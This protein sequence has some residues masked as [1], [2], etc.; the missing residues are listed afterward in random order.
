MLVGSSSTLMLPIIAHSSQLLAEIQAVQS[1]LYPLALIWLALLP[2]LKQRLLSTA[3]S[4]GHKH[5][6]SEGDAKVVI[7]SICDLSLDPPWE[8][9]F[10]IAEIRIFLCNFNC[11]Q[12]SF[13][14]RASN[15][16][17]HKIKLKLTR[18]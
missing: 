17:T 8:I 6:L 15:G 1:S 18:V 12:F 10:T 2:L 13:C 14:P 9:R 3:I 11:I 7:D 5:I 4:Q 16:L